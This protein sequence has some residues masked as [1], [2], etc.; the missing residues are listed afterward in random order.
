MELQHSRGSTEADRLWQVTATLDFKINAQWA[1]NYPT[2]LSPMTHLSCHL[3][4]QQHRSQQT[5]LPIVTVR[6]WYT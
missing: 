3:T 1:S 4:E 5:L 6:I 2:P